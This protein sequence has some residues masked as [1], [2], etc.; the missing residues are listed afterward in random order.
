M[1]HLLSL[2]YEEISLLGKRR[3]V[4]SPND[5]LEITPLIT[6]ALSRARVNNILFYEL[7]TVKGKTK[8][9]ILKSKGRIYWQFEAIKGVDFLNSSFPGFRTST[10]RL[11]PV[12]GQ[13]YHHTKTFLNNQ[14]RENWIVSSPN[15]PIKSKRG[16]NNLHSFQK[17]SRNEPR[18][19]KKKE[20]K[21]PSTDQMELK[22][23]L[24]FLKALRDRKLI[25]DKEYKRKRRV[26]LDQFL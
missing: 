7:D 16:R 6:K 21:N 8:G 9:S 23:R 25:D 13:A 2:H 1:N 12:N 17:S 10:W 20:S 15:L 11:I 18:I 26:L 3:Y 22:K 14:T 5:A 4:F 24:H 19:L